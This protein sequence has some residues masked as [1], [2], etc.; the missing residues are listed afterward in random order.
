M[1]SSQGGKTEETVLV[2]AIS[3]ENRA[4]LWEICGLVYRCVLDREAIF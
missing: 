3:R 1:F 4:A 2:T